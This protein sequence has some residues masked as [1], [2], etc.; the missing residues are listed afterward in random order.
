MLW[1]RC[2]M[3]T[4][5]ETAGW[6]Y[7]KLEVEWTGM[8]LTKNKNIILTVMR[9]Y[10]LAVKWEQDKQKHIRL[11]AGRNRELDWGSWFKVGLQANTTNQMCLSGQSWKNL[12]CV[13]KLTCRRDMPLAIFDFVETDFTFLKEWSDLYE[14][15]LL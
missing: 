9:E 2:E 15:F 6:R 8:V 10:F 11:Q 12:A 13:D 3:F 1:F 14:L 4:E 5:L 7:D